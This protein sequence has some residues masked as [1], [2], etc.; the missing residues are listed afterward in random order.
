MADVRAFRGQLVTWRRKPS[1][2]AKLQ[3]IANAPVS[4]RNGRKTAAKY[5]WCLTAAFRHW[6][7]EGFL[8]S[9][10]VGSIKVLVGAKPKGKARDSFSDED[11]RALFGG[12]MYTGCKGPL[13][14]TV[15][16]SVVIKDG[17][18]W[19]PLIAALTGMRVSEI[20]QLQ[21]ADVDLSADIPIIRV[22]GDE[23]AGKTVK[24]AAGWR[25]VPVHSLLLRLGFAEFVN[26]RALDGKRTRL[27][28]DVTASATGGA[29]GEFSKWFGRRLTSLGIKRP[30]LTFHSF[31]HRFT[32]ELREAGA[33]QYII[34]TI[35]GHEGRTTADGYGDKASTAACAS[36][37]NKLTHLDPLFPSQTD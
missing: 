22:R 37:V 4:Q 26:E 23:A 30:T 11:L 12:P 36:W 5:F 1:Q 2:G 3:E 6:V 8:S 28:A 15:P 31:R 34:D 29:G 17:Y 19:V 16:G 35:V 32:Q 27:F 33:P 14:R 24:T 21:C 9:S 10:P 18:Y 25:D 20:V 13:R 7:D